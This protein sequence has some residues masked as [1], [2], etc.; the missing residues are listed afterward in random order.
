MRDAQRTARALPPVLEVPVPWP[1]ARGLACVDKATQTKLVRDSD[2]IQ[3]HVPLG[4][5]R[6]PCLEVPWGA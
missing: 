1:R 5:E 3:M 6:W 2:S 4:R